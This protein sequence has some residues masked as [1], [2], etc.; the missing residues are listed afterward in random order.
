M[1][2]ELDLKTSIAQ[3]KKVN[4]SNNAFSTKQI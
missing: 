2:K 1:E 4:T 3:T